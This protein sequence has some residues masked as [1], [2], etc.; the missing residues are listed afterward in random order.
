MRRKIKL[1]NTNFPP[2]ISSA[3]EV[4]PY[5][6]H[7]RATDVMRSSYIHGFIYAMAGF[8]NYAFYAMTLCASIFYLI[9]KYDARDSV[10]FHILAENCFEV[11]WPYGVGYVWPWCNL[12][13][14]VERL[15]KC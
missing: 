15:N 1:H 3:H 12:A 4:F 6:H 9:H 13:I 2:Y 11:L 5:S 7:V 14:E 10:Q 8:E